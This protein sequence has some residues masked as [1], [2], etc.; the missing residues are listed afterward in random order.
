MGPV[1]LILG[2][3]VALAVATAALAVAS[4]LASRRQALVERLVRAAGASV[5]T[6]E[7][8]GFAIKPK[9]PRMGRL[10][11]LGRIAHPDARDRLR[12]RQLLVRAGFRREGAVEMF[13]A[14]KL[15]LA[16]ALAVAALSLRLVWPLSHLVVEATAVL[17]AAVGFYAPSL[18]LRARVRE[19]AHQLARDLPDALDL[20]VIS[21]EAG[22]GLEAALERISREVS[23]SAPALAS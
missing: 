22:L 4:A 19:R 16:V 17:A 12:A 2:V 7:N 9:N 1:N 11:V 23:L 15:V 21:V 20:L 10:A 13:Y 14:V 5:P 8:L 3:L 18:W 6:S